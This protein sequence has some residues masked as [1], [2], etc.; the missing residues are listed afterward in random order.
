MWVEKY[1]PET[2]DDLI[3]HEHIIGTSA[4]HARVG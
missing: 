2:L 3:S 4:F 1:R